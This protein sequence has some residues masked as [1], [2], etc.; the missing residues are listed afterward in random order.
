MVNIDERQFGF[1]PGKGK[2][3]AIFVRQLQEKY[4]AANKQLHFA[5]F[6]PWE[7]LWSCA[8]RGPMVDR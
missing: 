8:K 3:D 7:S 5:L 4:I 1:V 6:R 2:T